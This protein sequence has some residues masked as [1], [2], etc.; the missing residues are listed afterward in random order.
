MKVTLGELPEKAA[1]AGPGEESGGAL[2]G[3]EV[4]NLTSEIAQQLNLRAGTKGVVV[5][6]IDPSSP[7]ASQGLRQGDVIQE[8][9]HRAVANVEE[10]RRA[11]AGSEKQPVLL[12]VNHGGVTSYVVVEPQ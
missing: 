5:S 7:A 12:L 10:F 1:K 8:V 9:N 3:V 4:E 2:E 11:L 6:S